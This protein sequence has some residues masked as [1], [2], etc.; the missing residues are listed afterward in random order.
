MLAGPGPSRPFQETLIMASSTTGSCKTWS[1]LLA[2]V[3]ATALFENSPRD[4]HGQKKAKAKA[5][6]ENG[7]PELSVDLDE[8]IR[9]VEAGEFQSFLER[10]APVEV[11]RRMRQEDI[12]ERAAA[13]LAEA[14]E[15]KT[16][17]AKMLRALRQ[18]TPRYDKSRGLATLEFDPFAAGVPEAAGDLHLPSGA[19]L[20]LTGIGDDLPKALA[21]AVK[22]LEAN[23]IADLAER[24]FPASEVA[25][26]REGDQMAA[27]VQQFKDTPELS[28]AM[29]K[30][31]KLMQAV[32]PVITDKGQV[33]AFPFEPPGGKRD[34][35]RVVKLQKGPGG[36]R[37]FDDAPRVSAEL[38]RQ[39][40]LKPKSGVSE[41]QME[42]IGGNWRFVELPLLGH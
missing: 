27:L 42:L 11:L 9:L 36:W 31:L 21:E 8:A 26:L 7:V 39:S 5:A 29:L 19:N 25:R 13:M 33:A 15:G 38:L 20:K 35:A 34:V 6:P 37:L 3:L 2:L 22:L 17:L 1:A 32:E 41:V 14:P 30:E 40:K 24:F 16:Q 18:I 12:V 23:K 10:Y 28:A 4:A